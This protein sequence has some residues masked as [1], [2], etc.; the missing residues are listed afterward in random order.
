MEGPWS[1]HRP[2]A[3]SS[4]S[5]GRLHR[6]PRGQLQDLDLSY[7]KEQA[8]GTEP[9]AWDPAFPASAPAMWQLSARS[10]PAQPPC[11]PPLAHTSGLSTHWALRESADPALSAA[12]SGRSLGLLGPCC[13]HRAQRAVGG[14]VAATSASPAGLRGPS[15]CRQRRML[16]PRPQA[17][18]STP[19][20]PRVLAD[21]VFEEGAFLGRPAPAPTPNTVW[22]GRC[23]GQRAVCPRCPTPGRAALQAACEVPSTPRGVG[24]GGEAGRAR[25]SGALAPGRV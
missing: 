15:R 5:P 7:L 16:W 24:G 12:S 8:W 23:S 13:P 2:Q 9:P 17:A 25:A 14:Q 11:F 18:P 19:G 4:H 3:R 6:C 20:S 21:S 10:Q 22:P 1:H